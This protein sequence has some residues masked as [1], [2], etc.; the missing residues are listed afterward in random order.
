[1]KKEER[2][3]L[4]LQ[5]AK[6]AID[7]IGVKFHLHAGTALGAIRNKT[8]IPH[9]H[10]IDLGI[11][12]KSID[13][14]AKV[15]IL[16]KAM[17][18]HGFS[19]SARLGT[20]ER[21]KEIQFYH[22]KLEVP[23][24]IFWL[25]KGKYKGTQ[26]YIVASYYGACDKMKHKTCIW[27]YRP[28]D[29]IKIEFLGEKYL[30][31][32]EKTLV[33]MYGEDWKTPKKFDYNEGIVEGGYKGLIPDYFNPREDKGK[34]AFCFLLYDVVKHQKIWERFFNEDIFS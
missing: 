3:N 23:L 29:P 2:F 26:Y 5:S 33:D 20:I 15:K 7:S 1:M 27:G 19:V 31:I 34:I 25:Y 18:K 8:F 13:T 30:T 10:D 9:D 28:Y 11:F 17:R 14:E 22:D 24:D 4:V 12:S 32:P 21:G 16:E 6:S